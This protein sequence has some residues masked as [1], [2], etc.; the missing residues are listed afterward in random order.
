MVMVE[1]ISRYIPGVIGHPQALQD[2]T[3]S[4]DEGYI[5]Y[6]QYTRP[7]VFSPDGKKQLSVPEILLS[8]NHEA[9]EEWREKN[10]KKQA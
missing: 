3:F 1:A 2:E 7:E 10:V 4:I 8:G 6:P 5:E 9:I